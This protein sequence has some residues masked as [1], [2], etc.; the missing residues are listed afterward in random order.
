MYGY[1]ADPFGAVSPLGLGEGYVGTAGEV[2]SERWAA[3]LLARSVDALHRVPGDIGP[4]GR[5]RRQ[6]ARWRL[7]D[8]EAV[9]WGRWSWARPEAWLPKCGAEARDA[10]DVWSGITPPES[11]LPHAR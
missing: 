7:P 9:L 6:A 1:L 11:D 8:P 4:S 2:P 3:E 10:P 5:H